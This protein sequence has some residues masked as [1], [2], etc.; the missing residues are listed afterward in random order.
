MFKSRDISS[1]AFIKEF[2]ETLTPGVIPREQFI[3]WGRIKAKCAE[4]EDVIEYFQGLPPS[5]PKHVK[6]ELQDSLLSADNPFHL[7]RG[8]FELLGHTN[9]YYV[10]DKDNVELDLVAKEITRGSADAA[11]HIAQLFLDLGLANILVKENVESTFLGVQVGLESN[12]RKSVGGEV[13][14]QWATKLLQSTCGLLGPDYELRSEEK[15]FYK[16]STNCKKVDFAILFRG[17]VKIGIEVNFYTTSG[18]KPSE[19]KR[20]YQNVNRELGKVGVQLVWITDGAGYVKMRRSL[21]EAFEAHRN[22]YNY[23][24]AQRY[25]KDDILDFLGKV[26]K[27]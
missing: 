21:R 16:D 20:A 27:E 12:R 5:D 22:T 4:F 18:S 8:I 24:M 23:E 17:K 26:S 14:N 25:L 10:S 7:L 13:F 19:I 3:D 1:D 11:G 6:R 15:I 2:F 9:H